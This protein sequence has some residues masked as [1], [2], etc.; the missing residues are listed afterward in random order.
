MDR[1]GRV[2]VYNTSR[3]TFLATEAIVANTYS[4]RLI[5]LLGKTKAWMRPGNGLWIVPSR[6]VHTIGML[7][8]IDLVFLDQQR[9]VIHL[10]EHIRPFKISRVCLRASTVLE[11]PPY[12]IFRT[13]TRLGDALEI[14]SLRP[15]AAPKPAPAAAR[16]PQTADEQPSHESVLR[17]SRTAG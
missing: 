14:A 2:Y 13:G 8:P 7:F 3:E 10:E 16:G 6:G 4:R 12:T 1:N 11:L 5:G 17:T 9:R 15:P